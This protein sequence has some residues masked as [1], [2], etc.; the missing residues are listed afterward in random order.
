MFA[1]QLPEI[2]I[3]SHHVSNESCFLSLFCQ[4]PDQIIC[5]V[6]FHHVHR[7]AER[8]NNT[9]DRFNHTADILRHFLAVCFVICK[10][11]VPVGGTSGW[12]KD[13]RNVRG[14][15]FIQNID[16]NIRKPKCGRSVLSFRIDPWIFCKG[17][18]S[19]VDQGKS[20]QQKQF[21]I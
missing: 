16:Q 15:F 21:F 2:L 4:C 20:I 1:H 11:Y 14:L 7:D 19:P 5:F 13:H 6:S 10:V 9:L 18:I 3:G 12:V 8:F 17:K